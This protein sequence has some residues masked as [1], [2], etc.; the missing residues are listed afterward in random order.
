M[1]GPE[2]ASRVSINLRKH[3]IVSNDLLKRAFLHLGTRRGMVG[4]FRRECLN[5]RRGPLHPNLISPVILSLVERRIGKPKQ[6]VSALGGLRINGDT[7][8]DSNASHRLTPERYI[9][10]G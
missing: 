5:Q 1:E 6:I 3:F 10:A 8:R 9:D 7:D 4:V 2:S